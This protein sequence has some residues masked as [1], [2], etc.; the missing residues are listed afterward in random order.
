MA[1]I[2]ELTCGT[3]FVTGQESTLWQF[4]TKTLLKLL[5]SG[6][7]LQVLLNDHS[8]T[9]FICLTESDNH[10]YNMTIYFKLVQMFLDYTYD[11]LIICRFVPTKVFLF[12]I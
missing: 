4:A 12:K 9:S 3:E 2:T 11:S 5:F 10:L 6:A 7:P 8:I 1:L